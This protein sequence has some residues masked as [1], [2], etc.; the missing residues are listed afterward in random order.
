M[1]GVLTLNRLLPDQHR[2]NGLKRTKKAPP[3]ER[4]RWGF[5]LDWRAVR[6]RLSRQLLL[7]FRRIFARY[8]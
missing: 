7:T 3:A 8:S 4:D 6:G 2:D 1:S 5:D